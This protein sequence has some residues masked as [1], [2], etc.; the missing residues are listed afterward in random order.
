[1]EDTEADSITE[2]TT[3]CEIAERWAPSGWEHIFREALADF[4]TIDEILEEEIRKCGRILP[5]KKD[6]FRAF[7]L[8]TLKDVKVVIIGQDP[9][10]QLIN[11]D[12][13]NVPRAQGLS[14]SV[15]RRDV[16][17]S[18]LKNIFVEL[19]NTVRNFTMPRHGDLTRWT[20]QGVLLLNACLTVNPN[21]AASHGNIW[22]GFIKRVIKAITRENKSCIFLL[23][24][25]EA[26]KIELLLENKGICLTAAHPSGLSAN[27]GFFGC[28][29]F[30]LVNIKLKEQGLTPIDWNLDPPRIVKKQYI[31]PK[32][33]TTDSHHIIV[34]DAVNRDRASGGESGGVDNSS[35][36]PTIEK[37]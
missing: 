31:E 1:M 21:A 5:L 9:Y 17:P 25:K 15:D 27:R 16:I 29:H 36:I 26:Q 8:T 18:S 2:D 33:K 13:K 3:I 24:G 4:E 14:F 7:E 6:I 28:N 12:G 10:H 32:A 37:L 22:L 11:I 34:P 20:Q 30:N 19:Q 35:V 23:W